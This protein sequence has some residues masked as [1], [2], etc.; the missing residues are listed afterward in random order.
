MRIYVYNPDTNRMESFYRNLNDAMPYNIGRTLTVSEFRG[1]SRSTVL[2]TDKRYIETWNRFRSYYGRPIDVRYVFRRIW[3]GGHTGQSQHYAGGAFDTAHQLAEAERIRLHASAVSFGG[4]SY[5]EPLRY[6]PTWVHF[7]K[8]LFPSACPEGGYILVRRG[9]KGVYVMILQDALNVLGFT[10]SG[11]DGVFGAG[12]EN[13]VRRFQL[14]YGLS[15]DGI[16]G[17]NTWRRITS[18]AVGIGMTATVVNP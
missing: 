14:A 10:G 8:R 4:W 11:L 18:A 6:T 12:T 5:V 1:V 3:E 15:V 16:V 13:A 2:W 9:S 17:C 7:D